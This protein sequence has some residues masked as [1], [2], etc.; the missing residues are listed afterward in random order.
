MDNFNFKMLLSVEDPGAVNYFLPLIKKL[1]N[2]G[3]EFELLAEGTAVNIFNKNNIS[4]KINSPLL[5]QKNIKEYD[6]VIVGTSENVFSN[7]L[8]LIENAK[9][10][11]IKTIGIID[12]VSNAEYR[13]KGTSD[14]KNKYAP[15]YLFVPD[16]YTLNVYLKMGYKKENIFII[17]HPMYAD[18]LKPKESKSEIRKKIFPKEALKKIIIVFVSEL[19]TGLN[20]KSYLKNSNYTL[21]GEEL[22]I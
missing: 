17:G 11:N 21:K 20:P 6:L 16:A 1:K 5:T 8:K 18:N 14:D 10:Y 4:F 3:M 19:S 7:S 9:K 2:I 15:D 12:N 13:F 22:T